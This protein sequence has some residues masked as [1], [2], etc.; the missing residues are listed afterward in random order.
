[1]TDSN[2]KPLEIQN[3]FFARLANPRALLGLFDVVPGVYLY[4]KDVNGQFVLGNQTVC[5][6]VGVNHPEQLI[7]KT[8]LDFFPPAIATQY[9]A[10]DRRVIESRESLSDQVWMVPGRNGIP[11]VYLC[12][13]I[14]LF[15]KKNKV[16]GIAGLK[17]PYEYSANES[18]GASRL[19][20]VIAFVT[21]NYAAEIG[22]AEM[23]E[24]AHLSVSQ[25]QREFSKHF[26]ITPIR[27]LREVRIGVVRH[28]LE[29]SDLAV[30]QIAA[31]CGFYDQSHLTRNFQNSTG[32]TPLKYRKRYRVTEPA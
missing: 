31:D 17:R 14:P 26:G 4:I 11:R 12:S 2:E 23:A 27:Y 24:Q 29:N 9:V 16:A 32:L 8:D 30:S 3:K 21:E 25:L 15:D 1:M 18:S 7:G 20:R 13:K 5:D 19:V 6:V 22:V 28:M 10:E